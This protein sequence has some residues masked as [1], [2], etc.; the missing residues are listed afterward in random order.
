MTASFPSTHLP[1]APP[2][3]PMEARQVDAVPREPGW[4]LE[5]K[6]DG[7]RC[8]AFRD[9]DEIILQSKNG[10]PLGRYFPELVAALAALPVKRFVLDGEIVVPLEDRLSFGALLERIHPAASRVEK[11]AREHPALLEVFDL[12]VDGRGRSLVEAPLRER[13]RALDQFAARALAGAERVRLSPATEDR[14]AARRWMRELDRRGW[15]GVVAKRLDAPY[16]PGERDAMLKIKRVRTADCVIGGFRWASRGRVVGSILLGLYG[17]DGLLHH[18][19]F[20]A[21]FSRETR[22]ALTR[23][24]SAIVEPPGFTGNAPGGPSRWSRGRDTSWQPVRPEVVV[25]VRF[26]HASEGRFRHG[27]ELVRERP[28]K[29]ARA[30]TLAQIA[31]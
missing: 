1:V 26:D 13:R 16:R 22:L 15:D 11:L 3:A 12:L 31:G 8:L 20:C 9:G 2:L 19:G 4:L 29:D 23:R 7:F 5:P 30:C 27:V 10:Q 21:A 25:E 17:D 24:L 28:D 18:V 6:W 14:A